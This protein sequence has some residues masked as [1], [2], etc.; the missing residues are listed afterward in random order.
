[1]QVVGVAS[2]AGH[3]SF[4]SLYRLPKVVEGCLGYHHLVTGYHDLV[5]GCLGCHD[6]VIG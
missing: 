2:L 1:M 5:T 3:A 6:L 4:L